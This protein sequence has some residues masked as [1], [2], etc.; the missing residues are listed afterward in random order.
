MSALHEQ[1][2]IPVADPEAFGAVRAAIET[3]FSSI[4]VKDFLKSVE[5]AGLRIRDFELVLR[6]GLLGAPTVTEYGRLGNGDQGQ[7]REFYL[8]SLEKVAPEL[9]T[10]FYKLYA[11]Y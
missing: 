1:A 8:A 3:A 7:I 2:V 9:R 6:K 5:R 11:Y 4:R 10:E